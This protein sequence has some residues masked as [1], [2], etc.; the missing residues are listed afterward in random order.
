MEGAGAV[1]GAQPLGERLRDPDRDHPG[2]G[3][4]GGQLAVA[5]S[6]EEVIDV[7]PAGRA[8]QHAAGARFVAIVDA[9]LIFNVQY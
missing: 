6:L 1:V 3:R 7:W 5:A 8:V 2:A 9:G 4:R